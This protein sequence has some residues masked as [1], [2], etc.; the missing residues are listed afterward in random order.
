MRTILHIMLIM[1]SLILSYPTSML[2]QDDPVMVLTSGKK[3]IADKFGR[4][5]AGATISIKQDG[6]AFKTIN[7]GSN[8]K[9]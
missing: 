6:K 2:A 1:A 9:Y 8:G 4:K 3:G 5:I 7:T